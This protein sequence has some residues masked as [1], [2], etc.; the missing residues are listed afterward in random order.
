[1]HKHTNFCQPHQFIFHTN[2]PQA[3]GAEK[4]EISKIIVYRLHVIVVQEVVAR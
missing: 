2:E 3:R 1:M 4:G